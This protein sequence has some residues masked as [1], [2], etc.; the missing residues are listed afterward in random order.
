[1][2]AA[3]FH[4]P[5]KIIGGSV[6]NTPIGSTTPSTAV[7]TNTT[8]NGTLS[9]LGGSFYYRFA[10]S[11]ILADRNVTLPLLGADDTFVFEDHAATLTNKTIIDATNDVA[12]SRLQYAS[13]ASSIQISAAATPLYDQ[14]LRVNNPATTASW[15]HDDMRRSVRVATTTAGTLATDFENGDSVDGVVLATNDRILIKNQASGIENGIYIVQASGAPI[16]AA[17]FPT[18]TTAAASIVF[19]REGN[20]NAD[21]GFICTTNSGSDVVGTNSISWS[22]F[23]SL[24]SHTATYTLQSFE[25][26]ANNTTWDTIAYMPW[27]TTQHG[28]YTNGTIVYRALV[29]STRTLDIRFYD[30]TNA[31]VL[32]SASGISSTGTYTLAISNPISNAE[33]ALQIQRSVSGSPANPSVRGVVV[34]YDT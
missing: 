18:G 29:P 10:P 19:A 11:S 20:T 8:V 2:A 14:T 6:D 17:D 1:M 25:M 16:R 13:G 15:K 21:T 31:T 27:S 24:T 7:F 3:F 5:A 26:V 30:V 33:V 28:S 22:S 9:I 34:E 32:G 12:A 23:T 4:G